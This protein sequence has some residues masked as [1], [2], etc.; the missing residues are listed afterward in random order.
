MLKHLVLIDFKT[1]KNGD[2]KNNLTEA[3]NKPNFK[4][5]TSKI[6]KNSKSR[7]FSWP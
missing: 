1:V 3:C 5:Q 7:N 2:K 4:M 6:G